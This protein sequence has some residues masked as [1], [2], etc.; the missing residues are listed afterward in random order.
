MNFNIVELDIADSNAVNKFKDFYYNIFS[1][2]FPSD[3]IGKFEDYLRIKQ[4]ENSEYTYHLLFAETSVGM[5]V[6]CFIYCI[7]PKLQMM[8]GEF[9]C[10]DRQYRRLGLASALMH[11]AVDTHHYKWLFG[12]I[13]SNNNFNIS[14]WK[15]YGF[16]KIPINYVQLSL[17]EGRAPVE[18]LILCVMPLDNQTSISSDEVRNFV[19][20]YYR[21]SQ[22]YSDPS[23]TSEYNSICEQ[24]DKQAIF[25]LEDI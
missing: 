22:L 21:W 12:E 16:K 15:R 7:F 18:N 11:K 9:A 10:V 20:N 25:Q 2:C 4:E 8:V 23:G 19:Y 3:E 5:Y 1:R 13:E 24:C 6:A 14:T 17:G